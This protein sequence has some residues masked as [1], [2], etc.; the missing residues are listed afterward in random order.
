[1]NQ[2]P[3]LD[4]DPLVLIHDVARMMRVRADQKAR[5][6]KTTRAQWV[7]L[8]RLARQPGLSQ[9]E[10]AS[11]AE[12]EPITIARTI[13]R[14]EAQGLVERRRDPQDRRINRLYL[15]P[16][17]QPI[18]DRMGVMRREFNIEVTDGLDEE[19]YR[20][21]IGALLI[22]KSNLLSLDERRR[23]PARVG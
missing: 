10:L 13:D 18:L 2:I 15:K 1:M 22:I 9:N 14:L 11:A 4:L 7:T 6:N 3:N 12:V 21:L 23:T 19:N 17:A 8:A 20:A 16:A 5:A